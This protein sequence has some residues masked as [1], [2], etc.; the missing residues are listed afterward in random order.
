[1]LNRFHF[2]RISVATM[3]RLRYKVGFEPA[4]GLAKKTVREQTPP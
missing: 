3:P 1:M 4:S 2:I